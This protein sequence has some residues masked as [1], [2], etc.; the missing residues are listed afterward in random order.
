MKIGNVLII[1]VLTA[2]L[3]ASC[4]TGSKQ[5]SLNT[6]TDTASYFIGLSIGK[7]LKDQSH[8]EDF[9][10]AA[11]KKAIDDIYSGK[12]IAYTDEQI[13]QFL[14][15]FFM[16]QRTAMTQKNLEAGRK[17]LED[18]K[19]KPDVKTTESGLQ[20]KVVREG[21][22]ITP[23]P[24]DTVVCNYKGTLING[25]EFDSSYKRGEPAT[26]VVKNVIKGWQE[27]LEMMKEGGK[28]ELYIPTELAYG[29]NVRPG[30]KIEPNDALIFEIELIKVKKGP[31]EKA[32]K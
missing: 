13:Q 27:A 11:M 7:S 8:L 15:N 31:A 17:F 21:T 9:N 16:K 26:F 4:S 23:G 6:E 3:A 20:Y 5:V 24:N 32:G 30:G 10:S 25:E 1:L 19:N 18:N 12:E 2:F 28:W 22:G 29:T 14:N